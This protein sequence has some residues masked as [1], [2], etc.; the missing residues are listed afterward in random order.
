M[1]TAFRLQFS[2]YTYH[3]CRKY[4][5]VCILATIFFLPQAVSA[6][7][8]SIFSLYHE[9]SFVL[10]PGITGTEDHGV[11]A[12]TYRDQ[13]SGMAGR[14]RTVSGGYHTPIPRTK[15]GIGAH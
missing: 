12:A 13:W 15:M 11:L 7:Q 14:P 9:N 1:F 2:I 5:C 6:H 4:T 3:C 8:L 10:N